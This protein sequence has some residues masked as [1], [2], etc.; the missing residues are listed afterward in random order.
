MKNKRILTGKR[1]ERLER[2]RLTRQRRYSSYRKVQRGEERASSFAVT[3]KRL[4]GYVFE[5]KKSITLVIIMCV[6]STVCNVVGPTYI[7]E[8]IDVLGEQVNLKVTGHDISAQSLVPCILLLVGV[9]GGMALFAFIQQCT[10]AGLSAKVVRR[11]RENINDKLSHLP[12][13]Y[14]D[15]NAKGDILSRIINDIDNISNTLQNNLI[16]VIQ[17]VITIVG[18]FVMMIVTNWF[19]TLIIVII[20]PIAAA[21]ALKIMKV[22][23]RLFRM[24]WDRMGELNGHVEEMYTG[25][26]IVRIFGQEQLAIDEFN[27]INDELTDV[28]M[29]AQFVSGAIHPFINLV[30]NIGYIAIAVIGGYL[31]V[32]NGVFA[33]GGTVLYDMGKAFTIGGILT[34]VTYSKLFTSPI[35]Q[36]AQ[37][38]NQLQSSMASGERV[39]TLLDEE[40][41]PVDSEKELVDLKDALKFENV[42]FSYSPDKPL[43]EHLNITLKAGSLVALV[44]PTGAGK[45]TFVNLLM[46]FYDVTGGRIT[47]DGKDIRDISRDSLRSMFGMVL[48]DTWLFNGTVL[49]NLRYGNLDAT[50]EEVIAAS[51]AAHADEFISELPDGYDTMLDENGENISQGQRQLI[52]I[53]RALLKNPKILILDEATSSVDTR[54][55]LLVQQAMSEIM[56]GR[57]NFV[58]AHRLSTIRKADEILFIDNGSVK[59]RGTHDELLKKVGLYADMYYSQFGGK[60]SASSLDGDY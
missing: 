21:I 58:I 47:I 46:R 56:K 8:A 33:I 7:G 23:K 37:I 43:M 31:I 53:A 34:F 36:F 2:R 11:L 13:K 14:F 12:L 32:N 59:E 49:E 3:F 27:D 5:H 38:V 1:L 35:S 15:S 55:E 52:T 57:T 51:K 40:S 22:S 24:Q 26:K 54:T 6:L 20:V 10:M 44:G 17:S 18:V 9:Y 16:A 48:Q 50:D 4:L 25:H 60:V 41:E 39:F 19:L 28:S 29:R 42:S 45:T 30:D